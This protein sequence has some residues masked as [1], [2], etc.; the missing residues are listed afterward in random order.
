MG[1]ICPLGIII[2]CGCCCCCCCC[3]GCCMGLMGCCCWREGEDE[4]PLEL[5]GV[6]PPFLLLDFLL[7]LPVGGVCAPPGVLLPAV[8]LLLFMSI[9]GVDGCGGYCCCCC[10]GFIIAI[11]CCCCC[12][13]IICGLLVMGI[14]GL[15][16]SG[17][18]GCSFILL[19][20]ELLLLLEL[21]ALFAA[22]TFSISAMMGSGSVPLRSWRHS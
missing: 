17:G 13:F 5:V 15:V 2:I 12:G 4:A 21:L 6:E 10:C 19:F 11:I 22:C 9:E 1:I 18:G 3:W 14:M 16:G 20:F 7:F 8:L